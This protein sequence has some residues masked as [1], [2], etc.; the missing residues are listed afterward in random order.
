MWADRPNHRGS[1]DREEDKTIYK[2]PIWKGYNG[3]MYSLQGGYLDI[4]IRYVK[5]REGILE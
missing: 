2:N 4:C 1:P 5:A 3:T